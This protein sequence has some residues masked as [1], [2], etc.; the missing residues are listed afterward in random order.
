VTFQNTPQQ[1][2][3]VLCN[4]DA[5]CGELSPG[6]LY[7]A[8]ELGTAGPGRGVAPHPR[9]FNFRILSLGGGS[10][11]QV[12]PKEGEGSTLSHGHNVTVELNKDKKRGKGV[13]KHCED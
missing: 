10:S 1:P 9:H 12:A 13:T 7:D 2:G 6:R 4:G 11:L 3:G 5:D 8:M